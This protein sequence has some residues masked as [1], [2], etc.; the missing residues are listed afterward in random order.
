MLKNTQFVMYEDLFVK[1]YKKNYG[2]S[3]QTQY[4]LKVLCIFFIFFKVSFIRL[5]SQN[6]TC[7]S[8]SK[9]YEYFYISDLVL[10]K[11][12]LVL[13]KSINSVI[14]FSY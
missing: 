11:F 6:F 3:R 5:K 8:I 7:Y 4:S 10:S 12:Q 13:I 9:A 2:L 1:K 14:K